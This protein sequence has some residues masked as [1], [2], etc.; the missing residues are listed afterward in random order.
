MPFQVVLGLDERFSRLNLALIG[1]RPLK[2]RVVTARLKAMSIDPLATKKPAA[3]VREMAA[4][5]GYLAENCQTLQKYLVY[6]VRPYI[7]KD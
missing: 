6:V 5:T 2:G 3:L 7:T 1:R 4:V